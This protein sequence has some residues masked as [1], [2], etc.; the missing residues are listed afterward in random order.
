MDKMLILPG[1][2]DDSGK[3]YPDE[4]GNF[5]TWPDGAL[6][7]TAAE[8]FAK[9]KKYEPKILRIKGQPQNAKSPQTT[10]AV[11]LFK[12]D[13]Q[14]T[15]LY[16]FSGGGYNVYWIL[17]ALAAENRAALD[18]M[19][20]VVVLGAPAPSIAAIAER[21]CAVKYKA[22]WDLIYRENPKRDDPG[23]PAFV[24]EK[25]LDTHMFGPEALLGDPDRLYSCPS[26]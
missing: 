3:S 20:L 4:N 24:K 5:I 13:L 18:R 22:S 16:G 8:D 17:Q 10:A 11:P 19:K 9:L 23:V 6:H 14:I 2:K 12:S 21:Y 26:K 1:N 15:A 25:R 7:W